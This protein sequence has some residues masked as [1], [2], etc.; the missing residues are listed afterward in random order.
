MGED[1]EVT[2][3][4]TEHVFGQYTF[5]RI[6][7]HLT[8]HTL[9]YPVGDDLVR[10]LPSF[11]VIL[12]MSLVHRLVCH[13]I[14]AHHTALGEPCADLR[15]RQ[16]GVLTSFSRGVVEFPGTMYRLVLIAVSDDI[17]TLLVGKVPPVLC[18]PCLQFLLICTETVEEVGRMQ[19]EVVAITLCVVAPLVVEHPLNIAPGTFCRGMVGVWLKFLSGS[20]WFVRGIRYTL[21]QELLVG[22]DKWVTVRLIVHL[23]VMG[24]S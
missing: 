16:Q 8:S 11:S 10:S 1:G 7:L 20:S 4:H 21:R 19:D 14:I 18:C 6:C 5:P 9:Y 22:N 17:V 24:K 13:D 3:Q 15:C 23:V 2:V 12:L